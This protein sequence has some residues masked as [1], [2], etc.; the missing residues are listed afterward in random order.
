MYNSD[1]PLGIPRGCMSCK[2]FKNFFS[3]IHNIIELKCK[4]GNK[5]FLANEPFVCGEYR[6]NK[7]LGVVK[8]EKF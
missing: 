2:Y 7:K 6:Q 4:K 1:I 8:N 3:P 5:T